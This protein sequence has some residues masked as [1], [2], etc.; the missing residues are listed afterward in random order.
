MF[1]K[2][3]GLA[4]NIEKTQAMWIG[5]NVNEKDAICSDLP[6]QW[7]KKMKVLGIIFEDDDGTM[8]ANNFDIKFRE[9]QGAINVWSK[10]YLTVYGKI[11][12]IK[13]LLLPK[14]THLFA[15]LRSPSVEFIK[16]FNRT[17][18]KFLWSGKQDKVSRK[19]VYM[20]PYMGG[21]GMPDITT[22]VIALK[23]AWTRREVTSTHLWTK[24]FTVMVSKGEFLWERN[25]ESLKQVAQ[26]TASVFWKE[27]IL[28]YGRYMKA[29][30]VIDTMDISC[31]NIWYSDQTKFTKREIRDWRKKG[32]R[33]LN[34]LLDQNGLL[35]NFIELKNKFDL[36]GMQLDY[37]GLKHS[38]PDSWLRANKVKLSA[39]TIH[40]AVSF[41]LSRQKGSKYLY[42]VILNDELREHRHKWENPWNERFGEDI[43]WQDVYKNIFEATMF[44]T[45]RALHYKIITR[46]HATNILLY[47]MG[48]T[49][50]SRC[51]RCSNARDT[52]EH[53][54][55]HCTIV[56]RFWDDILTWLQA[57]GITDGDQFTE[58][59]V[60]LGTSKDALIN[61][62]IICA[63][64][65]IR[66]GVGLRLPLL[67]DLLK[68]DKETEHYIATINGAR[69][70]YNKKWERIP[71]D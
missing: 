37:S 45:Y 35:L 63:K 20:E 7:V 16:K 24:L 27:V 65:I 56:R 1:A 29:F 11:T 58:S 57:K 42:S 46:I 39:P 30:R 54:F 69:E 68:R 66:W 25:E 3:S 2:F 70:H 67:F 21:L 9:M 22:Y 28:A 48:V 23:L 71:D 17:L 60:I 15:A 62:V 6:M 59:S 47:R 10:R 53:T 61:H 14:F 44:C 49:D 4:P 19:S 51:V 64:D 32:L 12:I 13:S 26:R 36:T 38:L 55:W 43:C 8:C 18:F 40:P 52:L 41:L 5:L 34:D 50:S 33:T 31:C